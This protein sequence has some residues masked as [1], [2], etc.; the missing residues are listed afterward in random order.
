MD[1]TGLQHYGTEDE[2]V[3]YERHIN[4]S[5]SNASKLQVPHQ[6]H[7]A[8]FAWHF[9]RDKTLDLIKKNYNRPNMEDWVRNYV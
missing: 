6:Y 2:M 3:T 5:D 8:I 9:G 1:Y 4:I 7:D